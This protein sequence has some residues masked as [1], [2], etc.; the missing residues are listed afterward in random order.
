MTGGAVADPYHLGVVIAIDVGNSAIKVAEV[1]DREVGPVRRFAT[2]GDVSDGALADLLAGS[3]G[4]RE[5]RPTLVVVS[6]VPAWTERIRSVANHLSADLLEA[7]SATIPLPSR[8]AHPEGVGADRLLG[9]WTARELYG[10]PAIV[11]DMGTATTLDAVDATGAFAGGAI[12]P[13][14]A[15]AVAALT[16][17]TAQLPAVPLRAPDHAIGRDTEE[18]IQSGVIL[19]HVEAVSGL[20]ARLVAELVGAGTPRPTVVLTG[21]HAVAPWATSVRNVDHIDPDLVL[22]GLGMLAARTAGVPG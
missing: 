19:G 12:L 15:L 9:A 4:S 6:V 20:I 8:L 10:A 16:S 13:G 14:P 1:R 17:G 21:G 11:V 5:L 22:R 18:A 7:T 3:A 2:H